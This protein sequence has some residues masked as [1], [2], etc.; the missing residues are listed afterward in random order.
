MEHQAKV[1][2]VIIHQ[3]G[4]HHL[5]E[6]LHSVF[7]QTLDKIE[8]IVVSSSDIKPELSTPIKLIYSEGSTYGELINLGVKQASGC[9]LYTSPS[10]RD[11]G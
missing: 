10:P 1:S 6:T 11:R 4:N 5:N 7:A 3:D 2:V 8:V 9:L